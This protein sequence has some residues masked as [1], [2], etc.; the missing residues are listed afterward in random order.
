MSAR[1]TE[2]NVVNL[3]SFFSSHYISNG[4]KKKGSRVLLLLLKNYYG[5]QTSLWNEHLP[6]KIKCAFY[7]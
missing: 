4:E 7:V 5:I 6:K 2:G 1:K 3:L